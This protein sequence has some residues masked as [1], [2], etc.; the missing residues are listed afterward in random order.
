MLIDG[1]SHTHTYIVSIDILVTTLIRAHI[2]VQGTYF[3]WFMALQS[4][5]W[6]QDNY[7]C[8]IPNCILAMILQYII[9]HYCQYYG[10]ELVFDFGKIIFSVRLIKETQWNFSDIWIKIHKFT[11]G[12]FVQTIMWSII[13]IVAL[14]ELKNSSFLYTHTTITVSCFRVT[15]PSIFPSLWDHC[16]V[17]A[18]EVPRDFTRSHRPFFKRHWFLYH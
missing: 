4:Y 18:L 1:L 11:G 15:K 17:V 7:P 9:G 16:V 5:A 10:G 12:H 6:G 14:R 8:I 3:L 2:Y 13:S